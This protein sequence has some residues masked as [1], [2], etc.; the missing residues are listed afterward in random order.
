MPVRFWP[1]APN[2]QR[3]IMRKFLAVLLLLVT[4]LAVAGNWKLITDGASGTRLL[5][6]TDSIRI[7]KY[8]KDNGTNGARVYAVMEMINNGEEVVFTSFIDSDD[9]LV[10]QG[11]ALLVVFPDKSTQTYF[12]SMDGSKIYDAEGQ[13]LCGYLIGTLEVYQQNKEKESKK[14]PKVTM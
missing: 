6:N 3:P 2:T 13:W 5:V 4:T 1:L 8:K 14:K 9:C 12:W 10:Q 11:G 7:D